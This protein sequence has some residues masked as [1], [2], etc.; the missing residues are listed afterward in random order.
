MM[1][2]ITICRPDL[3]CI[4]HDNYVTNTGGN[5]MYDDPETAKCPDPTC[6][7]ETPIEKLND[8]ISTN[9]T[10]YRCEHC[11]EDMT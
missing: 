4:Q 8:H 3:D 11:G 7:E 10:P 2:E 6:G 9:T 1:G 5:E